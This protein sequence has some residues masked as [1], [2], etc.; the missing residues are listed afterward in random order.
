EQ[1]YPAPG[2]DDTP[3]PLVVPVTVN[4][5]LSAKGE[6]HHFRLPVKPGE[7][8][9]FAVEADV[10]GSALDGVLRV[11]DH[12]GKQLAQVDAGDLPPPAAG[13]QGTK[14]PDPKLELKVPAG[15]TALHVELRDGRGR[16]G[17]N[18]GYRLTAAPADDFALRQPA[19]EVNVPRG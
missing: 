7:R 1:T 2:K 18:F 11:A 19:A 9:R 6:A 17:V 8:Y 14:S 10:L 5:R 16:G 13:L 4:G 3:M 15:V 12:A